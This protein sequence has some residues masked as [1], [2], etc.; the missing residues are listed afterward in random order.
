MHGIKE[1]Q[2]LNKRAAESQTKANWP[3]P[4]PAAQPSK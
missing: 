3:A 1:I 4:T 2:E